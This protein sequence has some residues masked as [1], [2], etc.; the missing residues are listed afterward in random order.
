M[1]I[2]GNYEN[3]PN[4]RTMTVNVKLQYKCVLGHHEPEL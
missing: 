3:S 2:G 1:G 4:L